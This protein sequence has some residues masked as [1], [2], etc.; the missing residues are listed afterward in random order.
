LILCKLSITA[1][2]YKVFRMRAEQAFLRVA[3]VILCLFGLWTV[4][5]PIFTCW[6]INAFWAATEGVQGTC[7]NR[8]IV[9]FSISGINILTDLSLVI[10]PLPLIRGLQVPRPQKIILLV[11]FAIG[12]GACAMSV[13]RLLAL[14]MLS[15]APPQEQS[16]MWTYRHLAPDPISDTQTVQG[17]NLTIWS[18]VEINVAILCASVPPLRPLAVT[19]FPSLAPSDD[20]DDEPDFFVDV[21]PFA[22]IKPSSESR[23]VTMQSHVNFSR[24]ISK[25]GTPPTPGTTPPTPGRN[26]FYFMP[27][28][29]TWE[30]SNT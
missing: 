27:K 6:P 13:L 8:N 7:M 22:A 19:I 20:Y 15:L 2:C 3:F 12:F 21:S 23:P 10:M 14:Y 30:Q 18:C 24:P 29:A 17:V 4:I 5:G 9:A 25:H 28:S 26:E 11:V 16:G 1:Y